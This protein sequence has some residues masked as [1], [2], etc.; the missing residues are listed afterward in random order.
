MKIKS[1]LISWTGLHKPQ[2]L[3]L[4]LIAACATQ[5]CFL[6]FEEKKSKIENYNNKIEPHNI[7]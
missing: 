4:N 6:N 2:S 3:T 5:S 7:V 1:S